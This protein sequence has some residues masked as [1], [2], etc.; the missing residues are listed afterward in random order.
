MPEIG[1]F[2]L[3]LS[4]EKKVTDEELARAICFMVAA[5]SDA[6]VTGES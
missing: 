4:R 1:P 2:F 6:A 3:S 5:E